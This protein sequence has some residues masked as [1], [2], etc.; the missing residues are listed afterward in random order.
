MTALRVRQVVIA[1][2]DLGAR[3]AEAEGCGLPFVYQD[4]DVGVF[5]AVNSLHAADDT[6]VELLAERDAGSAVGRHLDRLGGDGGYMVIVQV[7]DLD[8]HLAL[9]EAAG[10]RTIFEAV[11]DGIRGVHLHPADIG[12]AILSLD[13]ADL[14]ESWPWCGP[15][16]SGGAPATHGTPITAITLTAADPIVTAA[17]WAWVLGV[18]SEG[19]SVRI[20]GTAIDFVAADDRSDRLVGVTIPGLT[21]FE[22]GG[23][24]FSPEVA[25]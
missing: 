23:V 4:P 6:F 22:V 2:G 18:A 9:V 17:R 11:A 24:A 5:G 13:E 8:D 15:I 1:V 20:E 14:P 7:D 25:E 21:G 10:I 12:S 16:W 19:S 3:A